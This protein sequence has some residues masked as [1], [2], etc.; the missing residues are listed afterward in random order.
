MPINLP[1]EDLRVLELKYASKRFG[2]LPD[3]DVDVWADALLLKINIIT[4]WVIPSGV[5][6][7]I[8]TDQL[9]KKL[10]EAYANLNPDEIEYAF[11]TYGT[12]VKDW[13]KYINLSLIDEVMGPYLLKR[14]ELSAIEEQK[15]LPLIEIPKESTSNEAMEDWAKEVSEKIKYNAVTIDFMPMMLYEWLEKGKKIIFSNSEKWEYMDKAIQY[16]KGKLVKAVCDF[17]TPENK[18]ALSKF[19][20][21]I[22]DGCLTGEEIGH[23]KKLA[24]KIILYEYL[25]KNAS[26]DTSGEAAS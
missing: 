10:T 23:V 26:I 15:M 18:E 5:G 6:L 22:E 24:K 7:N 14:K 9:R 11:R 20:K 1:K 19:N 8:I 2:E 12:T 21:M 13:G 4:G 3:E 25:S 16:R 17:D